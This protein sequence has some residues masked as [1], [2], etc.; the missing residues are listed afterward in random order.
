MEEINKYSEG[1]VRVL[2][3]NKHDRQDKIQISEEMAKKF[4]ED[5]GMV[6]LETSALS[7][8]HVSEAFMTATRQLISKKV[9]KPSKGKKLD[10]LKKAKGK[11]AKCC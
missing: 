10:D 2:L 4:A 11:R 5:H 9:Q 6:Y 8:H 1:A 7:S 3:G